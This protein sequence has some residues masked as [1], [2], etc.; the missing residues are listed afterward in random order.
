METK[1]LEDFVSL[2]ETRSFSRSATLRHVTQ[3]AFSRRIQALEAWAGTDLVDRSSYP[4]RLTPA[5]ETLYSQSLE[6]LQ[7]LQ[8]TRAMLRGHNSAGQDVIEF[9]VPHSL[10]FTFFPAWVTS[11]REK[12]GPIKSR[13]IALNVHDAVMRLVEGSCDLLIAYHHDSQPFQLDADRYEMISLGQEV[14]AP[15]VKADADGAPLYRLPGRAGQPLPYLGY[16][17][18]AYLGRVVDLILKQSSTAIHL[19]RVYETDM[20]EGLKAMALEGH[21]I[22]FLPFSA[23]KKELRAKKLVSAGEGLEMTMDVRVYRERPAGK[24]VAKSP[25]QALWQFL[26]SQSLARPPAKSRS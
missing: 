20:A 24:D 7:G 3:P 25:A 13:L 9:A 2:A 23:V 11:L 12:F 1:W 22:A 14:L 6:M 19:D 5:G 18:G 4:T 17:P 10:A 21:G 16:A 8:S 26:E 15:F